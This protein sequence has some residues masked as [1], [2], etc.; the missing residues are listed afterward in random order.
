M[1]T[2][3]E[4]HARNDCEDLVRRLYP[5]VNA[6]LNWLEHFGEARLTGTGSSVFAG[7]HTEAEAREVLDQLPRD[8]AGV[9][10]RGTNQSP[11]IAALA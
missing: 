3:F 5:E 7:F 2:F 9:V 8:W 11:V 4:G 6:A 1:A 10:A